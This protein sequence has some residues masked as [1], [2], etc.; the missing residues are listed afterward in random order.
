MTGH[1][2]MPH[3]DRGRQLHDE[4]LGAPPARGGKALLGDSGPPTP[5]SSSLRRFLFLSLGIIL[6]HST[7]IYALELVASSSYDNERF[8]HYG[9]LVFAT[10]VCSAAMSAVV[11]RLEGELPSTGPVRPRTF[12]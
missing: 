2:L 4:E 7:V 10:C 9:S 11:L 1:K 6:C 5:A 8:T 12:C 3:H